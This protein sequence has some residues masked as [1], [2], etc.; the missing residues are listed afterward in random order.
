MKRVLLYILLSIT[1]IEAYSQGSEM[2]SNGTFDDASDW[3]IITAGEWVIS[4][5]VAHFEDIGAGYLRQ[6]S[7]DMISVLQPNTTYVLQFDITPDTTRGRAYMRIYGD[8]HDP[9]YVSEA[10]YYEGTNQVIFTTPPSLTYTGIEFYSLGGTD[11]FSIDN[12]SLIEGDTPAGSPYFVA[13]D[14]NDGAD[15]S[16]T[17]PFATPERAF[18]LAQAGDSIYVRA[19]TYYRTQTQ[20]SMEVSVA[21]GTCNQ[22]ATGSPIFFGG[23]PPDIA[24]GD[25][26]IFDFSN[27]LP[28]VP[29][30]A[31]IE[32][33]PATAAP[34][35]NGGFS[36]LWIN[37]LHLA[38]F[39]VQNVWQKYRY[40][41]TRGI[42]FYA[43]NYLKL[44]RVN[45]KNIGGQGMFS[46]NGTI[47]T[48]RYVSYTGD[49][50]TGADMPS[51][52]ITDSTVWLWGD[53]TYIIDCDGQHCVDSF[54]V[55]AYQYANNQA[56]SWAQAFFFN[57]AFPGEYIEF[58][59]VR[60]WECADDGFNVQGAGTN[61]MK[62]CWSFHNGI[63]LPYLDYTTPG[64]GYKL[65]S[66]GTLGTLELM[67]DYPNQI[68][69]YI[70]NCIAAHNVGAGYSEN[71][72]GL[73]P[74]NRNM[75]NNLSY[76]NGGSGFTSQIKDYDYWGHRDNQYVNN[77]SYD[78]LS[79][80]V[81]SAYI[82]TE[83]TNSWNT[84]P[85]VTVAGSDFLA[86]PTDSADNHRILSAPRNSDGTL[87][88]LG[89]YFR[90]DPSSDLVDAGTDVGMTSVPDIGI[91]WDYYDTYYATGSTPP[92]TPSTGR[93]KSLRSG[94]KTQVWNGKRQVI[95]FE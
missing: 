59:G 11:G 48:T 19:G 44:E 14:G 58:E 80:V 68:S 66:I 69:H 61:R 81:G 76:G 3:T 8:G 53:S 27:V 82:E 57:L 60:A 24:N 37:H 32:A 46:S 41:Q 84:P 87:P 71:S 42:N 1:I 18:G 86:L 75:W 33:D 65:N 67:A 90:L 28:P 5:G 31:G 39:T 6:S 63:Y 77:L 40:I 45:V 91:D 55:N 85:G 15:G 2:I 72:N 16:I 13:T 36:F 92:A 52:T 10:Y 20:G 79:A 83:I 50:I 34:L 21:E 95:S 9:L 73:P 56:G 54:A 49:T 22:G 17:N 62:N 12:I 93:G 26:V 51:Y 25:S 4:G 78:N 30:Y 29:D 74:Q 89:N 23:Y 64:Q 38:D 47:D 35:A 7:T 88:D 43:C 94:G 70:T